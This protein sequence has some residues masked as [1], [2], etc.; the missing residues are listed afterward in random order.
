MLLFD[1]NISF[2]IVRLLKDD[3]PGCAHISKQG[4][5][6][7][8]DRKIWSHAKAKGSVVV[9]FDQDYI[10]LDGNLG[11]GRSDLPRK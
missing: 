5:L 2:R 6:G 11:N 10:D 3:Y 4:L 1:Q 7:A 9:T 8:S